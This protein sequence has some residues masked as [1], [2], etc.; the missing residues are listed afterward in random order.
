[1][2]CSHPKQKVS[3]NDG[4]GEIEQPHPSSKY[5]AGKQ[6]HEAKPVTWHYIVEATQ[7]NACVDLDTKDY[8]GQFEIH[9]S[10]AA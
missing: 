8:T 1:M 4:K 5:I 2:V 9:L 6:G 3:L 7:K 10:S